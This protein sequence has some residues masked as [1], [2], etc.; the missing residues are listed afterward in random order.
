M[1]KMVRLQCLSLFPKGWGMEPCCSLLPRL[2][3]GGGPQCW[4]CSSSESFPSCQ[5]QHIWEDRVYPGVI[6]WCFPGP[7]SFPG[8]FS[9]DQVYLD[10]ILRILR[11]RQTI[12]FPLLAALGKVGAWG[13]SSSSTLARG[14][15]VLGSQMCCP[16]ESK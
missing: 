6:S 3:P 13:H 11:H 9:K 7:L 4:L 16:G 15:L 5:P 8:C 10:G 14:F 1:C 2:L 12:D